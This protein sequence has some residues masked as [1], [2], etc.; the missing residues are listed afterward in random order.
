GVFSA[1]G[2]GGQFVVMHPGLDLVITAHN[3]SNPAGLWAD[4]RPALVAKDPKFK[5]DMT[6]FCEADGAGKYAP[7]LL[8]PR[9]APTMYPRVSSRRARTELGLQLIDPRFDERDALSVD[10]FRAERRHL[11]ERVA[12]LHAIDAVHQA[13]E[14]AAG[15]RDQVDVGAGLLERAELLCRLP[16]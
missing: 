3:A 6:A 11:R 7:D 13:R 1:Q 10:H 5:G 2:L 8:V 14:I 16:E 9:V 12:H 4:V 15:V